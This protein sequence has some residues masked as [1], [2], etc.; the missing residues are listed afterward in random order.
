M[1]KMKQIGAAS[2][3]LCLSKVLHLKELILNMK[4]LATTAGSHGN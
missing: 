1:V 3:A 2:H 4:R